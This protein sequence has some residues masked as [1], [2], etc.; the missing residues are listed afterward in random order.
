M[1][2][3]TSREL[4][5]R[6]RQR[7]ALEHADQ[8]SMRR[9]ATAPVRNLSRH[10]LGAEDVGVDERMRGLVWLEPMDTQE[11]AETDFR[12]LPPLPLTMHPNQHVVVC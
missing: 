8:Q 4:G 11:V 6:R 5:K 10:E 3:G 2:V 9:G 7:V 1:F 12:R